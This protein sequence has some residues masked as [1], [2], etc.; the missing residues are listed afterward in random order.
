MP[1]LNTLRTKF[2]IVLS[3]IIILAL[4]AFIFSMKNDLGFSNRDPKIGVIDGQN[5]HYSEYSTTL[6]QLQKQSNQQESGEQQSA[7]IANAAWQQMISDYVLM[8]GFDQMGL[9]LTQ[10][11]RTG[12][13]NGHYTTQTLYQY[14][15]DPR[16]GVYNV[17]AVNQFLAHAQS[18]AQASAQWDAL[19]QQATMERM[20]SKYGALLRGGVNVNS[21]EVNLG[22]DGANKTFAGKVVAHKYSTIP[23]S[24][25]T[26]SSSDIQAYYN[27]HKEV[28]K[29]V[30]NRTISYVV[31][32][33]TPTDADMQALQQTAAKVGADFAAVAQDSLQN[34]VR[35]NHNGDIAKNYIAAAQITD[36]DEAAALAAGKTYGPVLKNNEWTMSRVLEEK[37]APDTLGIR[38]IVLA[39]SEA[40]LADSLITALKAGG[41]FVAAAKQYSRDGQTADAGGDMGVYPFSA[42]SDELSATLCDAQ[43]GDVFRFDAG[44]S[45]QIMQTYR[46]DKASSHLKIATITYPVEASTA[47]R[48]AI[49]NQAVKFL[50]AAQGGSIEAFTTAATQAAVTPRVATLMQ[51]QRTIN[52]LDDSHELVRWADGAKKNTLSEVQTVGGNYVVALLTDIDKGEYASVDKVSS[53]IKTRLMRDKKFDMLAAKLSGASLEEQAASLGD[54]IVDFSNVKYSQIFVAGVGLEPRLVGAI[55]T[56]PETGAVSAPVKGLSGLYVF[57]VDSIQTTQT[58]TVDAEKVR[59][60]ATAESQIQQYVMPAITQMADIEDL[61]GQYF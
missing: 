45:I 39:A 61:R 3:I 24:T 23:D 52:G 58:Q 36:A 42:F 20:V 47:T 19:M 4:L 51:G 8:P 41:D 33:V 50:S 53:Q 54:S 38:H 28:F 34:F 15:A 1:S 18:D 44:N 14:F 49:N 37:M 21:L 9:K 13:I 35:M 32:D 10:Q 12:I 5:I 16:T 56:T 26:V 22:V 43:T 29:Q 17:D 60:Q 25:V 48:N 30:P 57:R 31:F 55:A 59:E 40:Q 27:A 6:D 2:G 11:E 46:A 7:A